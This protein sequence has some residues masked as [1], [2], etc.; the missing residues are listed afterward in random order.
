MIKEKI[1]QLIEEAARSLGYMIYDA[2]I[3]LKGENTRINVK[4]DSLHGISHLDCENYSKELTARLDGEGVLPNY[5][6]EISSPGI[7]RLVRNIDEFR[8]FTGSP[9]KIVYRINGE[10]S[11]IKGRIETV[12]D[13]SVMVSTERGET[14]I[15]YDT[16]TSANLD[17]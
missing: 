10:S 11:V 16:I 17:Y 7:K 13:T 15:L 6:L 5:S 14:T 1:S 3:Y 8:R 2:S 12:T 9:V 4:I